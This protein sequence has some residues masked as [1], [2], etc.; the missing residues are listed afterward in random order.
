[1]LAPPALY[2]MILGWLTALDF[3]PHRTA[4]TALAH[5]VTAV[6]LG[7]SLRPAARMRAL[8]SAVTVPARQRY[9]RA[10]RALDRPSL[11]PV[12]LTPVLVQAVLAL[13]G[14]DDRQV[15]YLALDSV[16][17]G[18]WE[19]FTLGLVWHRRVVPVAWAVLPYP[20]PRGQFTPTVCAL[21]R[22][23][24]QAWP[25]G[26]PVHLLAD[27]G[28]PSKALFRTLHAV[29]WEWT[30][31]LP[32]RSWVVLPQDGYDGVVRGLLG[33]TAPG[34]WR[35]AA[36]RYGRGTRA[37]AGYLT[38]GK[39]QHAAPTHQRGPASRAQRQRQ[40]AQR[41]G[42]VTSKH[43]GADAAGYTDTWV[44]LF[45]SQPQAA[46][47]RTAYRRRWATEGSYRDVQG[48]WDGQHGW[49]L[50]PVVTRLRRSDAVA[51][52][53]G[54]WALSSVVQTWVGDQVVHGPTPVRLV[55]A[56][57]TTTRRLSVWARGRLALTDGSGQLTVW[58]QTILN[59]GT[60]RLASASRGGRPPETL[61]AAA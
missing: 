47:A 30:V 1:M 34:T 17:C 41:Q 50:E 59:R 19:V 7:Q 29:G 12:R 16:R 52:V 5:Q 35:R 4:R 39:P 42:H 11:S 38:V 9:R 33:R 56:Q 60:A 28:F 57:W 14:I 6:L 13:A 40:Q 26:R 48:G 21:I 23:A 3:P 45:S 24:A 61:L 31:R 10:A 20:W 58:L 32:S 51:H 53:V 22:Q 25:P 27:R 49:D 54:L 37:S 15:T 46:R 55:S 44:V 18:P 2:A 8:L 43:R 36:G